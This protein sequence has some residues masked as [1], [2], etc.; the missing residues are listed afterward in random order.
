MTASHSSAP[1]SVR[2]IGLSA[3]NRRGASS[4][5]TASGGLLQRALGEGLQ[6]RLGRVWTEVA[7]QVAE[8]DLMRRLHPHAASLYQ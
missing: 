2:S 1:M 4:R 6:R 5:V 7:R 3:C 8:D